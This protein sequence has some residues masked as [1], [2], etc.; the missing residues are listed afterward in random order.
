M[1]NKRSE[2]LYSKGVEDG[3]RKD[4]DPPHG[5]WATTEWKLEETRAYSLGYFYA[6]G[7]RDGARNEYSRPSSCYASSEMQ[8]I[9]DKGWESGRAPH[10]S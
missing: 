3:G 10:R 1:E 9:Y 8:K 7:Q 2:Y 4:W 6:R 5:V